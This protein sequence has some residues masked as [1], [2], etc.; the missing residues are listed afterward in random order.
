LKS[1][2]LFNQ[3][4]FLLLLIAISLAFFWLLVPFLA[5]VFWALVLAIL[6]QPVQRRLIQW[7]PKWP[8]FSALVALLTA[9][10]VVLLPVW[11][12]TRSVI[13]EVINLYFDVQSGGFSAGDWI[14]QTYRSVP[15]SFHPWLQRAGIADLEEIKER[16]SQLAA[17]AVRVVGNQVVNVGQNTFVFVL[18]LSI[19]LYLLFFLLRDGNQLSD[20]IRRALPL[21]NHQK[22]RF[23]GKLAMVVRA[24]IKGNVAVALS[25]GA[26]GGL[27]FWIL[28]IQSPTLWGTVMAVLSLLPAV[29]AGLVW[30][31]VAIYFA[32][33]GDI[34]QA[35]I[36]GLYG[37][38]VIG[39]VDNV[40]RPLLVGKDTRMPDYMVLISTL[41]GLTLFG[42][43]GFIA[44]PLIAALFLVAWDLF[45]TRDKQ[46]ALPD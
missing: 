42:I 45:M 8:N 17:Q 28:G 6:F 2:D 1:D 16:V 23:L 27:I 34:I 9:V 40:L 41:S 35:V 15:D 43:S 30:G 5:A 29:G 20:L 13:N 46:L 22:D 33:T 10:V 21:A 32:I 39:L 25:Q 38:L 26:L 12:V 11:W 18:D 36:L 7:M 4:A 37:V 24:T 3:R 31:P 14:E 44:G 19:M